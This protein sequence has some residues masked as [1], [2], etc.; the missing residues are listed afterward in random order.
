MAI[1]GPNAFETRSSC[2]KQLVAVV[3][4]VVVGVVAVVVVVVVVSSI[5]LKQHT[6]CSPELL[7]GMQVCHIGV[8]TEVPRKMVTKKEIIGFGFMDD[9]IPS[10]FLNFGAVDDH[11]P[12]GFI[13][14]G[15]LYG[16]YGCGFMGFGSTYGYYPYAFTMR[17]SL[18]TTL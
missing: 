14:F 3:V 2:L 7:Q 6:H 4:V 8:P 15:A 12:Y 1:Q 18:P 9:H 16:Y 11:I 5:A 10:E 13:G 17:G